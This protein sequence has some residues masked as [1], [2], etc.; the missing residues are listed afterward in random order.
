MSLIQVK[1]K[2]VFEEFHF[3]SSGFAPILQ[4]KNIEK[5]HPFFT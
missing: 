3:Q 1:F 4:I 5:N 2:P